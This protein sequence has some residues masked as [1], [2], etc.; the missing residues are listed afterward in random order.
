MDLHLLA[1]DLRGNKC[2]TEVIT[3][4]SATI[5]GNG[6]PIVQKLWFMHTD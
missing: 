3:M 2:L 6:S 4:I 1:V 5:F